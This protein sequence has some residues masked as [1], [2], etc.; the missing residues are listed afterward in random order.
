MNNTII[1]GDSLENLRLI[2]DKSIDHV[3]TSPPYNMNLRISKGKYISRQVLKEEFSTKYNTF[4]DNLPIEEFYEYHKK[5]IEQLLRVTKNQIFY[6]ISIV[7]GS[8]RAFFK[9]I[10]VFS[11]NLKEIIYWDKQKEQPAMQAGVI[12]RRTELILVFD[13]DNPISRMFNNANF[14]RGT[15]SDLLKISPDIHKEHKA[16]FPL[17]LVKTILDNFT[18]EGDLILDPFMGTGTVAIASKSCNR[19]FIGIEIDPFYVELANNRL[20]NIQLSLF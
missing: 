7:T 9:L 11:D 6:N 16:S 10:G 18:K 20:K 19:R 8:K 14:E 5:V 3:I 1:Q 12:N 15:F 4:T 13:S 17:D 2:A